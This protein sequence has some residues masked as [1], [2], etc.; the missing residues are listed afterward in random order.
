MGCTTQKPPKS[1]NSGAALG[2]ETRPLGS[3]PGLPALDARRTRVRW[4]CWWM[5]AA[6]LGL[7]AAF[8]GLRRPRI[9]GL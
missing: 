9:S 2:V 1:R 6:D 7:L 3:R 4:L 5:S 8:G